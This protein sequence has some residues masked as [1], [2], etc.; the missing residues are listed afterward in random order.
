MEEVRLSAPVLA[1]QDER[2]GQIGKVQF[3]EVAEAT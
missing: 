2:R 1:N 3:A